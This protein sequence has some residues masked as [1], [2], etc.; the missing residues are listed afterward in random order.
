MLEAEDSRFLS[1]ED[2]V[3]RRP[4]G[5]YELIQVKFA[6]NP[7][8]PASSLNWTWLTSHT[9]RSTSLLAKWSATTLN[10]KQHGRL[11]S[12]VLKTD[13][14][15]DPL[16]ATSLSGRFVH[17]ES[18]PQPIKCVVDQQ[19]GSSG[20]ARAFFATFEF[21]HSQP[22][23][24]DLESRLWTRM[25]S[26]TDRGGWS[27]FLD[28]VR[29]WSTRK[30]RPYPDGKI[31][32]HH[33]RQAVAV[34]RPKPISQDFAVPDTY[35]SP[36]EL[37]DV[38]FLDEIT[39]SDGITVL[40]GPP[41]RGKSTYLSQC[42]AGFDS[43]KALCVRHHY[44]LSVRDRSEARFR[45]HA[46]ARSLRF[47]LEHKVPDLDKQTSKTLREHLE[48]AA[49]LLHTR[50]A[51]L[52]VIIDGLD[53]VWRDRRDRHEMQAL[54]D[55]LL[56][57]PAGIRLVIGTQK[58]AH[59]HLP[60]KLLRYHPEER[61]IELPSMAPSAILTWL[62]S[63]DRAG[64][65]H[66]DLEGSRTRVQLL[67]DLAEAFHAITHGLPL[68][69]VYSFEALVSNER[70]I[71]TRDV[72]EL[73]DCP[74]GDIREYYSSLWNSISATAQSFLHVLAGLGF[75]PPS[76]AIVECLG[77]TG[78]A[79]EALHSIN[80]L[81][82]YRETEV[83]AFHPSLFAFVRDLEDHRRL[84]AQQ[85]V[86][87]RSWL[88]NSAPPYW[89]WAWLWITRAQLGDSSSLL[90]GPSRGWALDALVEGY[91]REQ[92]VT[93]IGHAERVAFDTCNFPRFLS[94]RL[95]KTRAINGPDYETNDWPVFLEAAY[96]L[97][98]DASVHALL[99]DTLDRTD[100][101]VIPYIVRTSDPSV[102]HRLAVDAIS[103]LN[104]RIGHVVWRTAD[105][106]EDID[107]AQVA[108]ASVLSS[109]SSE[110]LQAI[111]AWA[112]RSHTTDSLRSS[113]VRQ[114][115][116]AGHN[117]DVISAGMLWTS[118][119]VDRDVLAALCLEGL[120]SEER[121]GL[122]GH[123]HPAVRCLSIL[124]GQEQVAY[125]EQTDLSSV[126][127]KRDFHDPAVSHNIR[128][129]F[130]QT[131]FSSLAV[132]LC[133]GTALGWSKIPI[134]GQTCW[135]GEAVRTLELAA[136]QFGRNWVSSQSWPTLQEIFAVF[137]LAPPDL[138]AHPMLS[139]FRGVS[140]ALR[141]IAFDMCTIS[142]GLSSNSLI[143]MA[144]IAAVL[145][146]PYWN[147]EGW[148]DVLLE[149]RIT[150]HTRAS[151]QSLIERITVSISSHV[152]EFPD[153]GIT[154]AKLALF[155]SDY[156]LLLIGRTALKRGVSCVVGY[157]WHKDMFAFEVLESIDMLIRSG[158]EDARHWL[159]DL[160]GAYE[161][162]TDYT[163]G[164]ETHTARENYYEAIA[165]HYP[166][167]VPNLYAQLIRSEDWY[168]AERVAVAFGK[169]SAVEC[170]SGRLLVETYLSS[171][172]FN[173]LL[174]RES[175]NRPVMVAA[176]PTVARRTGRVTS[177]PAGRLRPDPKDGEPQPAS[178][179]ASPS[180][181]P[182]GK[183]DAYIR[184]SS[185]TDLYGEK[186]ERAAAWL[187]HWDSVGCG[188]VALR[189]FE[190]ACTEVLYDTPFA[191]AFLVAFSISLRTQG[192]TAAFP[193]LTRAFVASHGW[194]K[195]F[196]DQDCAHA[197]MREVATNYPLRWHEFIRST[198]NPAYPSKIS[199]NGVAIGLSTLV[200]YLLE[201]DQT[202]IAIACARVMVSTFKEELSQQPIQRPE[203]SQ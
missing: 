33:L 162:I 90:E 157:G 56:P 164:D 160:A 11:G 128:R 81:L 179:R 82:H 163:D 142:L 108:I 16:F 168:Y 155:A 97:T 42:V 12:A 171:A 65:L 106:P 170:R 150:L 137:D 176:I 127:V 154:Y 36:D 35:C 1:I 85:A 76:F 166:N 159:L 54:F 133:G 96:S 138:E 4:D 188:R 169:T 180:D 78:D 93:I 143:D 40:W 203:W 83:V 18:L 71:S 184:E 173:G 199:D 84:F 144:D 116:I 53:H 67:H 198:A 68:H 95:L 91:P 147:D 55:D 38:S 202:D 98:G 63:Q 151:A 129:L 27:F 197:A 10:L 145:E 167:R 161:K 131:Y 9:R 14:I 156:D 118:P 123:S 45:Y 66:L 121:P 132:A 28:H 37:F 165:N 25:S 124:K 49:A 140:S 172:E 31:R 61:W 22:Q 3:A 48:S 103:V 32:F 41:G 62:E 5:K 120:S 196:G 189:E 39:T 115:L 113:Y 134:G 101:D 149:R 75:G 47:Q 79:I 52:V 148:I 191:N 64:R 20:K 69:L 110:M 195:W 117:N 136:D 57:L 74:T 107:A 2:V 181:Y 185:A 87:V 51:R 200:R 174:A 105:A 183:L 21:V 114:S 94:L 99:R 125:Q 34:E 8:A 141:D 86:R 192:R 130:Y 158:N 175:A 193:W 44:F 50:N 122:L 73:P 109:G 70:A 126:F 187:Q 190:A 46:I 112:K 23:I 177:A 17:Y 6:A 152:T 59:Q 139:V 102:R 29:L 194:A 201:V 19:I 30:K 58:I 135:L 80:H 92:L 119:Q 13:R 60:S 88:E 24:D 146:S 186:G 111:D 153:R 26:D 77:S 7:F 89:R 104:R 72:G 178:N 15:P 182:P 100:T 43:S